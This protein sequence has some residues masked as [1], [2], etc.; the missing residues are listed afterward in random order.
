MPATRIRA[1]YDGLKQIAQGFSQQA[2]ATLRTIRNLEQ[3]A[4]TL[5]QRD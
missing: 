5:R 4:S 1:D 2:Q 3:A